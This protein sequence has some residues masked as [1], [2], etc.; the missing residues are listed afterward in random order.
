MLH[1]LTLQ[2]CPR[3]RSHYQQ[4]KL[5]KS[6]GDSNVLSALSRLRSLAVWWCLHDGSGRMVRINTLQ[7]A[8]ISEMALRLRLAVAI[9]S[10][11]WAEFPAATALA[12]AVVMPL[13]I[14]V[15][16]SGVVDFSGASLDW[17]SCRTRVG[18]TQNAQNVIQLVMCS[19]SL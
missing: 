10:S 7:V 5:H 16:S 6:S 19:S 3:N 14:R 18:Q 8:S 13:V 12:V 15:N 17:K 2:H 9:T 1:C 11:C 4:E